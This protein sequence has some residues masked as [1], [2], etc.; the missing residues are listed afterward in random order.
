MNTYGQL[1]NQVHGGAHSAEVDVSIVN[2]TVTYQFDGLTAIVL[3]VGV[4]TATSVDTPLNGNRQ[5]TYKAFKP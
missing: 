3:P 5:E 2:S 4:Y 1:I